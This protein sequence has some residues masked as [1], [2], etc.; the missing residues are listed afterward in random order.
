M[1]NGLKIY[2]LCDDYDNIQKL[3][4]KQEVGCY[5]K[6]KFK[7]LYENGGYLLCGTIGGN[8]KEEIGYIQVQGEDI[9]YYSCQYNKRLYERVGYVQCEDDT[10]LVVLKNKIWKLLFFFLILLVL[11]ILLILFL[12]PYFQKGPDLEPGTKDF[13]AGVKLPDDYGSTRI[14]IPA[15]QPLYVVEKQTDVKTVL[16]NPDKNQ[17]YFQFQIVLDKTQE[18]IYESRLV[19]PGQAIYELKMKH[20]FSQ[21]VYPVTVRV[22]T[23]DLE[24][25]EDQMNGGEVKTNLNVVR[26]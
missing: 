23:Y 14:I 24:H 19:P 7:R 18:V 9:P 6:K 3:D 5:S 20:S 4:K 12:R 1:N 16:W 22:T 17:V 11:T 10:F 15:F 26:K 25:F 21:G 2:K 13:K 8:A